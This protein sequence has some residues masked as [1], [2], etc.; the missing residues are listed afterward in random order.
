VPEAG[1]A[2]LG[3]GPELDDLDTGEVV[4]FEGVKLWSFFPLE[5]RKAIKKKRERRKKLG[6]GKRQKNP[7]YSY[8]RANLSTP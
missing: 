4:D 3:A 6:G 8:L 5:V 7:S 1:R 2:D